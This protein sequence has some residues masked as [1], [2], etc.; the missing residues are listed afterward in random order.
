M[1]RRLPLRTLVAALAIA[2][3]APAPVAALQDGGDDLQ[4]TRTGGLT[5]ISKSAFET[6]VAHNSVRDEYLVVFAADPAEPPLAAEEIEV[7]GQRLDGSGTP[8][9][10]R[11]MISRLGSD[12]D[13]TTEARAPAVAYSATSDSYLV[14]FQGDDRG[15]SRP[16]GKYEIW[17]R[18]VSATGA[19]GPLVRIS[20]TG[21]EADATDDA[22]HPDVAWSGAVDEFLVAWDVPVSATNAPNEIHTAIVRP[23]GAP[24]FSGNVISST[25][26]VSGADSYTGRPAIGVDPRT[27]RW[28]VA[29]TAEPNPG[30][31]VHSELEVFGQLL[32]DDGSSIGGDLRISQTGL[33]SDG[34]ANA[35]PDEP[36]RVAFDP[37]AGEYLVSWM[38]DKGYPGGSNNEFEV[39]GQRV[40][41]TGG[42]LGG[43]IRISRIGVDG[44]SSSTTFGHDLAFN[45]A[46][47]EYVAVWGGNPQTGGMAAGEFDVF[48]QRLA[49]GATPLGTNFRVGNTGVDGE[50]STSA[51]RPRLAA[52]G[53]GRYL[54][55]WQGRPGG[56]K[57]EIHADLLHTPIVSI[58]D[59]SGAEGAGPLTFP[60]T[61]R[62]PDPAG[63]PV[64]VTAATADGSAVAGADYTG[65]ATTVTV[66]AGAGAAGFAVGLIDDDTPEPQERFMTSLSAPVNA[67]AGTMTA[68]GSIDDDDSTAATT[69]ALPGLEVRKPR[70]RNGRLMAGVRLSPR[71]TG[72]VG[73]AYRSAGRTT[74]F[75]VPLEAG[76]ARVRKALPRA[77]R[78]AR[79]GRLEVTYAGDE[80]VLG[81]SARLRVARR[82]ARLRVGRPGLDGARL[83]VKGKLAPRATG[84]VRVRV[85]VAY[86]EA[87]GSVGRFTRR[88][89][90]RRGRWVLKAALPARA[91][92]AGGAVEVLYKGGRKFAGE[93]RS[94][95]I[96]PSP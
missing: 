24:F 30:S 65:A 74:R 40:T 78:R 17:A 94:R 62:Y 48:G 69:R 87:D 22:L 45:P 61:L 95:S 42:R 34:E 82:P 88:K 3:G 85:R 15:G 90:T 44:S 23:T 46:S 43:S 39:L 67:L 77:Q 50:S 71:A 28:L 11:F 12:G 37:A 70:V 21:V 72:V 57:N 7:F 32:A 25:G 91:I 2:L 63:V 53:G 59:A 16:D 1:V 51:F 38:G 83:V 5:E 55:A 79:R 36:P 27:G 54:G 84:S 19:V 64:T 68:T 47:G 13:N 35:A 41:T 96:A 60:V 26:P 33:E 10:G 9:G 76:R 93:L 6:D 56:F 66:D 92:E 52:G 75:E 31:V 81:T 18:S 20:A 73:L 49:S 14:V 4:V 58:G 8:L 80:R 86:L 89:R 29:W